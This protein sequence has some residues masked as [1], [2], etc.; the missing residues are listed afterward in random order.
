MT[1]QIFNAY[2]SDGWHIFK[3]IKTR[4]GDGNAVKGLYKT[5][6]GWNDTSIT[7]E[8]HKNG[9]YGGV[10]P[11]DIVAIDWDVKNGAKHG[12][13]SFDQLQTD[14]GI[15]IDTQVATPSG[16][17][18]AY[19]R[20]TG[21]PTDTPKLKKTQ[22]LYPDI[23][24]QSHGSEFVVLGGQ[25]VEGYGEYS[26]IDEDFEYYANQP[27]DF[28]S[29]ELRANRVQ[30]DGYD[31]VEVLEHIVNRPSIAD[32]HLMLSKISPDSDHDGGWATVAMALNS[33]DLNGADGE[34]LFV[35]WSLTS[36]KYT[37]A[38]GADIIR[39]GAATK[40]RSSVADSP[41]FYNK[42]FTMANATTEKSVD[43]HIKDATTKDDLEAAAAVIQ[44]SRISNVKR[45]TY[46][47]KLSE[48]SKELT[49]KPEKVLWKKAVKY[50]DH[51]K[52]QE[53]QED[54]EESGMPDF[55]YTE[56]GRASWRERV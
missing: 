1:K 51:A 20:L 7:Y 46:V 32:V 8:Y 6:S 18:H 54:A 9:I 36:K 10:P 52:A 13:V 55:T 5:P 4:A 34:E 26:F 28:S 16:G 45:E 37:E 29:L 12:D 38:E 48:K 23:E 2:R 43:E 41:A 3:L 31:S 27:V 11:A 56:I 49:G 42:L 39:E 33:W 40:Y 19:V 14:L 35:T 50:V 47:E 25:N 21:L 53:R 17:G 24:F 22:P 30:G 44:G 15:V